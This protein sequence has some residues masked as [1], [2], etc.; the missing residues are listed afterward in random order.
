MRK[1]LLALVLGLASATVV[2]PTPAHAGWEKK[3]KNLSDVEFAHYYALRVYMD[4]DMRKTY[5]KLKTEEERNQYLVD[6]GLWDRFYQYPDFVRE[7]IVAGDVQ[8]GWKKDMV[9]LSWGRPFDRK[10]LAGRKAERSEL[11][12]YRFEVH[13]DKEGTVTAIVWEPGSKTDYKAVDRFVREITLDDDVVTEIAQ[14][15]ASW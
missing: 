7:Q 3:V 2:A 13:E 5:L 8:V 6:Q 1:L 11:F 9:Y 10:K 4:D 12:V 15:K 14:K